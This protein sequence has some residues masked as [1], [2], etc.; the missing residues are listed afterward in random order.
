MR[1][2]RVFGFATGDLVRAVVTA[3][4]KQGTYVGRVVVRASG[5][6]DIQTFAEVV[7]SISHRYCRL[8]QR[9]DGYGYFR[10]PG[11]SAQA[12]SAHSTRSLAMD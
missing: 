2:K 9:G 10:Q 11:A 1:Q 6:F 8:M 5:S 7:Q 4:K 12:K 3:G